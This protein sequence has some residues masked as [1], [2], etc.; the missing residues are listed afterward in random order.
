MEG[1]ELEFS[2]CVCVCVRVCACNSAAVVM[3]V[4][5]PCDDTV[6][7]LYSFQNRCNWKE[8]D[9]PLVA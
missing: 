8:P 5:L 7:S 1:I 4:Q 3:S 2:V 9:N 6:G